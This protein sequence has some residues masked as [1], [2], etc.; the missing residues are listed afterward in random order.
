MGLGVGQGEDMECADGARCS[1]R[2]RESS[3][4]ARGTEREAAICHR[5]R[6]GVPWTN[7]VTERATGGSETRRKTV[8]GRKCED[9]MLNGF[10]LTQRTWSGRDGLALSELVAAPRRADFWGSCALRKP[11]KDAQPVL[12]RI[13]RLAQLG[14]KPDLRYNASSSAASRNPAKTA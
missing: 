6:R 9:G 12:G 11:P 13:H 4:P 1:G 3:P 7:N 10:G 2:R 5:R 14:G 8:R